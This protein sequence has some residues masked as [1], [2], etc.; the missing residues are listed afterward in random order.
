MVFFYNFFTFFCFYIKQD[1][2]SDS[3]IL[4]KLGMVPLSLRFF[5]SKFDF[6]SFAMINWLSASIVE[7]LTD[8]CL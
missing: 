2:E 6:A 3:A 8:I 7:V 1:A 4:E 5:D